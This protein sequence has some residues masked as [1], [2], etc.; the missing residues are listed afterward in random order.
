[1]LIEAYYSIRKVERYY[2]LF[3]RAFEIIIKEQPKLSED[4]RL[5][6]AIKAINDITGP[7]ELILTL[8]VFGAYLRLI[9]LDLPNPSVE[10]R[11]IV[12][13]KAIVEVKKLYASR[14]VR[15]ALTTR[16]GPGI[17]YIYD[18]RINNNIIV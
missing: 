5:Q 12:V 3:R 9:E 18:L 16:N 13:K 6:I 10:E 7:N 17:I 4:M 1:V 15:A 11:A 8:L 14:Q 2:R